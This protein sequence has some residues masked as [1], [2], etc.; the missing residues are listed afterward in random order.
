MASIPDQPERESCEEAMCAL[1]VSAISAYGGAFNRQSEPTTTAP[2]RR[3]PGES[4]PDDLAADGRSRLWDCAAHLLCNAAAAMIQTG[5]P[6]RTSGN[7]ETAAVPTG[8]RAAKV[9][10]GGGALTC[11]SRHVTGCVLGFHGTRRDG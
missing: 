2:I 3:R 10:D 11:D 8:H 1:A 5:T 6:S 7:W 4:Q 9:F